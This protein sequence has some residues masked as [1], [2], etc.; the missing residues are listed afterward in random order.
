MPKYLSGRVKRTPQGSLT[1]DRYQYLG[2]EQAEPNLGDP[3]EL[4]EIPSGTQYQIVSLIDHPGERFWKEIGG[5]LIPAAHTVRTE[6]LVVPR[7]DANPNLGI[8]SITDVNFVG[9]AI[10]V[11]GFL[12]PDGSPGTGVTV[13]VSAPGNDNEILFNDNGDFGT[14]TLFTFDNSTV[15]VASVGIGTTQPTQNLHIVGN[16]RLENIFFDEENNSGSQGDLLVKTASG[17]LKYT[18]AGSVTSGAGGTISQVQFHDSTGLVNGAD[19][20]VFDLTNKRVG[21]GSTQ[22]DR[23]LDVLGNSRFTGVA[24]FV[25][26][27]TVGDDLLVQGTTTLGNSTNDSVFVNAG[28]T[29][30]SRNI[31]TG[32]GATVGVG[33]TVFFGDD[34]KAVFGDSRDLEIYHDSASD[35]SKIISNSKKISLMSG[36]AIEIEDENGKQLADF[37]KGGASRLF[38][39]NT[40]TAA[41]LKFSTSGVGVTVYNQLDVTN[42]VASGDVGIGTTNPTASNIE[43]ALESNTNVLAV[44]IITA[45]QIFGKVTTIQETSN[46]EELNVTGVTSTKNLLVTGIATFEQGVSIGGTLTYEDVTNIDSVGLVT[47]RQGIVVVGGGVSVASGIVTASD[48]FEG[49]LSGNAT[50]ANTAQGLTG[51]PDIN[52]GNIVGTALS[53]SGIS[54]FNDNIFIGVGATV[55]VGSTVFFDDNVKLTFGIGNTTVNL[56][57]KPDTRDF[58]H[59]FVGGANYVL[60]TDTFDLKSADATKASITA[61]NPDGVPEVRLFND[62]NEKLRTTGYGVT[63]F[64]N[65]EVNNGINVTSGVATVKALNINT[66]GAGDGDLLSNGGEDGIFGIFNTT[67]SA[68][69]TLNVKDSE[70]T[71]NNILSLVNDRA[72]INGK[73]GIGTTDPDELL[74]VLGNV[75]IQ[76]DLEITGNTETQQVTN[77]VSTGI[78][79]AHGIH[80]TGVGV[81]AAGIS[82]FID[83]VN[84]QDRVLV[85][86]EVGTAVVGVVGHAD[87]QIQVVGTGSSCGI[88]IIR[89]SND[90]Q[91][92][93][94]T[95]AKSRSS[96]IGTNTAVQ[97]GDELGVI[98][99]NGADQSGGDGDLANTGA[100]IRAIVT[101]HVSLGAEADIP[102]SLIFDTSD[103]NEATPLERMRIRHD[104]KVGIGTNLAYAKLEIET[105]TETNSDADYY[106]QNFAI[107]VRANRGNNAGDE[108]NGIVFIQKWDATSPHLVRT[109][110]ILGY[111]ESGTG[112]FG[113]GLIFK[114]QEHGASPMSEKLRITSGGF[115]GIGT[116]N[117]ES[118]QIEAPLHVAGANNQGIVALFGAKDFVDDVNYNYE[119]A[120]I[121]LQGENPAGTYQGAGVQYI[122]RNPA[123]TNWHH[124]YTTFDRIGD[125]HIGL[126]GL[127]NTKATD[128]ITIL[129]TGAVGIGTTDPTGTNA[130][131]NNNTTLAVGIVT[132]NKIFGDVEGGIIPTGDLVVDGNLKVTGISTFVGVT[133]FGNVGIGGSLPDDFLTNKF[134]V[135]D[136]GGSRGMTIYSDGTLGQ[137]YFADGNTGDNRKRGGIVYDH[138]KD[139]LKLSVDADDKFIIDTD[140][141]VGIGTDDPNTELEIQSAT[142]PK[143]RL[144]SQEVGNKRLDLYVD[145]GEAVG[146]I[147]ADQSASQLAFRTSGSEKLRIA[148]DGDVGIGSTTPREKLDVSDGR[149]ILDQGYQLTWADGTTNRARI[150]G[151]SGS[152][153]IVE[154]GSGNDE[155]FRV[156]SDG[157]KVSGNLEVTG[158]LTY[159]DVTNI[160]SV[161]IITAQSGINVT[162]AG[163]SVTGISTFHDDVHFLSKVGIGTDDPGE[164]LDVNGAI[165]LRGNNQT[166][167]AAVLKA[168][169]DSTH[170]LSLESYHNS[171]TAFEVIGTH[172]D[173][174]GGNVR[175]AIAKGGQ[176]VGIG[177]NDPLRKVDV[178]GN[179]LLVRPTSITTLH[180]SGNASAV[181]NSIIVRMPYGENA[182]TT[183]NAGARFGIQFTGANN[184]TDISSLNFGND[185]QKSAS[186]YGVSEDSLG[187]NRKVGMA[188]YTSAFDTAQEERVRITSD[189]TVNIG[190]D[191]T[192]TTYKMKVTGTVAATNFDSLSDQKLKLNI[193][194]IEKPIETVNKI[195]GVTFNWKEDNSPSMGV[196]AQNIEKVLPEIVSGDDTKSVNFNGLIGLLIEVVK[197]QQKQIDEL[198]DLIDK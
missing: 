164:K 38:Y 70:G 67:D 66:S 35:Q 116:V 82:T 51:S 130:L 41:D 193:K 124:G 87:S 42:I 61:F 148:S 170:T 131:T 143:I 174:G 194:K 132:A 134:V 147:A 119:D 32:I 74:H 157:A 123:L 48:G 14:S 108:G 71:Y 46:L 140:G 73:V 142:D 3:P 133:T 15:G 75:K 137:I 12:N 55:G 181:N 28:I 45:N 9:A 191:Y 167:Y 190:G 114:T 62:G 104:G 102:A 139:E 54:T 49:D 122:T 149:I 129:S 161:G 187:Y 141:K 154:V 81:S 173:S 29:S 56:F 150:H 30:F 179:S 100:R 188:F 52:V 20:F 63:V 22:P 78:I 128:K 176:N 178:I 159:E 85:G 127:G 158:Q 24:T 96:T 183:S 26:S 107:A 88:S 165:R 25:N 153:F 44:G 144:Q 103:D 19:N 37:T 163:I 64:G 110:A 172:A 2:L 121:G 169:F 189:G 13:T 33:S 58:R 72:I 171:S 79:T 40:G 68:E 93:S 86:R 160:D 80:V 4:R 11:T 94:L 120:T 69:I 43:S 175:V 198:R 92:G 47:A 65:L 1:T 31:I 118:M 113:G 84:F 36:I 8:N 97:D 39:N 106:G 89:Y 162:G 111:K 76:G 23:L 136:G 192:Q 197:D 50:S 91:G 6:G 180:S 59:E 126:G 168:N 186:I 53:I 109:G 34:V 105:G 177:T 10:T 196:I 125:F 18:P 184:T 115:V 98:R 156:K 21:I 185:P 182:A 17:G 112:N 145:G 155:K 152:N 138:S 16:L 90:T 135:G 151:D 195:D 95:F 166:T 60:L 117:T 83:N 57:Y 101:D 99:F 146:I 5:G 7:T 77:L 27:V